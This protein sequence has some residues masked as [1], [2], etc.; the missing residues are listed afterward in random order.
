MRPSQVGP[1]GPVGIVWSF[2]KGTFLSGWLGW[3]KDGAEQDPCWERDDPV[4]FFVLV[5]VTWVWIFLRSVISGERGKGI[6]VNAE[7]VLGI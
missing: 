1:V 6:N 4:P 3:L 7:Q 5:H 2:V